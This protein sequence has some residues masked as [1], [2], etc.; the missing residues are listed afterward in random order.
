MLVRLVERADCFAVTARMLV[1]AAQNRRYADEIFGFLMKQNVEPKVAN[2]LEVLETVVSNDHSGF[3]ML[4]LLEHQSSKITITDTVLENAASYGSPAV[5]S[6]LL[7]LDTKIVPTE[8]MLEKAAFTGRTEVLKLLIKRCEP[9]TAITQAIMDAAAQNDPFGKELSDFLLSISKNVR[10]TAGTLMTASANLPQEDL[11][12]FI[13]RAAGEEITSEFLVGL[14]ELYRKCPYGW[15]GIIDKIRLLLASSKHIQVTDKCFLKA[16]ESCRWKL[17]HAQ[18]V[19]DLLLGVIVDIN[20]TWHMLQAVTAYGKPSLLS[21]LIDRD[22]RCLSIIDDKILR[23]TATSGQEDVL[24]ILSR[25]GVVDLETTPWLDI[26]RVRNAALRGKTQALCDLLSRGVTF[27]LPDTLGRTPLSWA[28]APSMERWH[29]C[30]GPPV[31]SGQEDTV[32]ALLEA[33]ANI[34][35]KCHDGR[36]PLAWAAVEGHS[37]VVKI[38]LDA[39]ANANVLD[40]DG[41]SAWE[42]AREWYHFMVAK[43]LEESRSKSE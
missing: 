19:V 30:R 40:K 41:K 20:V 10:V 12:F 6:L 22:P 18:Q 5:M 14:M 31:G 23:T 39:G 42:L 34:E 32:K 25:K 29:D 28:A 13:E 37:A 24:R 43:T 8:N 1:A 26:A 11:K 36:T 38:L 17:S 15:S 27:D 35:S 16:L 3:E 2:S 9:R 33:G 4:R 21:L 7:R